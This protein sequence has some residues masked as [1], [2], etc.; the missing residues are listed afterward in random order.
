MMLKKMYESLKG[1]P[2]GIEIME[3]VLNVMDK[4]M[5]QLKEA[6]PDKYKDLDDCIY[7]IA[8]GY[9]FNQDMLTE[10]LDKMVNDDGS[11]A[12]KWTV[13]ETTQVAN[14][15]GIKFDKFNEYD[16]NY[17]MNMIYSD[18]VSI[19]GSNVSSYAKMAEKFLMDKDAPEGKALRYAMAMKY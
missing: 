17:V 3:K 15:S 14:S 19:L 8:N 2:K 10:Y 5:A 7:V 9:H 13:A 4:H 18:Y 12:P 11:K 1:D 6:H 16:W